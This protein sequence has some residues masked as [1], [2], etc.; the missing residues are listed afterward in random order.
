MSR[1]SIT[2]PIRLALATLAWT[3]SAATSVDFETRVAAQSAIEGVYWRH[4]IWPS[5]EVG[6]KPSLESVLP[7]AALR[8]KVEE[9]LLESRA[10]EQVWARPIRREELEAEVER[11]STSTRAPEVLQEIFAALGHDST[12]VAECLARPLLADRLIRSAYAHDPRFHLPLRTSIETLLVRFPS[13]AEAENLGGEYGEVVWEVGRGR[14]VHTT[15]MERGRVIRM[16]VERWRERVGLLQA[17]FERA[18]A[19]PGAARIETLP[20]GKFGSLQEDDE[21]FF[22]QAVIEK[23][24]GRL[25]LATV[26]WRKVPFDS[27]WASTKTTLGSASAIE[28]ATGT[29][30][31]SPFPAVNFSGCT[32]DTW[33]SV[34]SSGAPSAREAHTSVWTG[35]EMIVWGGYNGTSNLDTN[36]GARY[37]PATDSWTATSTT[38][39]PAVRDTHTAVWTGSKMVIWGGG[40][41]VFVPKNTGGRYDPAT[42][43]WLTTTITGAPS[44][45]LYHTATWSGSKMVV[46]GGF[47]GVQDVNTGSR[48]DP[49][50]DSWVATATTTGVPTSRDSHTAV[51]SGTSVVVWGGEDDAAVAQNTGGRYDPVGNVWSATTTT[52]AA[53]ARWLHT[54]VWNGTKMMVWGGYDGSSDL[55]TGGSYDPSGDAWAPISTTGAPE[56][57]EDHAAVWTDAL[58]EMDVWGGQN[59]AVVQ[60]NSGGRYNASTNVWTSMSTLGAPTGRRLAEVVWTGSE[61]IPWG[62]W[63]S[64]DLDSGGRYC[65]GTCASVPPAGTS[66]I[67]L[68][69][70]GGGELVSWTPVPPAVAFDLV[71]GALNQLRS[72]GGDFTSATQACLGNDQVATSYLD[73]V[74]PVGGDGFWYLVRGVSCGGAGTYN[75]SAGSQVGSRDSE[76]NASPNSCP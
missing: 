68:S 19:A 22:V 56:A 34:Q 51:W 75:E 28:S 36:T 33:A 13:L 39:A 64:V 38:G 30:S 4:R 43:S 16:D 73:A 9:Y 6:A 29:G 12:L 41:E 50:A 10:L 20:V 71:R 23:S 5:G 17:G 54:A 76:I 14:P 65:S 53:D 48:Y 25:K 40:N 57:R 49:T 8:A 72:S 32:A 44:A 27:W 24:A 67:T 1:R 52:S 47:D 42:N 74:E 59:N 60:L 69:K 46:W 26:A 7:E 18:T 66:T 11:M 63:N 61:M 15:A 35:T 2:L 62:G 31:S 70:Q 45:R 21:S 3:A 58:S 55:N 37:T